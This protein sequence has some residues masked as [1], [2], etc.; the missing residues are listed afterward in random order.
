MVA[1][2]LL[3]GV[4][5]WVATFAVKAAWKSLSQHDAAH[6]TEL[7]HS[8]S[9]GQHEVARQIENLS[10]KVEILDSMRRILYWSKR[11]ISRSTLH[12]YTL[13]INN[14]ANIV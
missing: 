3:V 2:S 4:G 6:T 13:T 11:M 10:I 7:L 14:M 5:K 8:I 12:Y 9:A 1:V